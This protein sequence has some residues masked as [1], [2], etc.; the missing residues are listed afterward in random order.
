MTRSTSSSPDTR[1][2][3]IRHGQTEWNTQGI[4]RGL[5][6]VALSA[7]GL[8]EA[9]ALGQ[10]FSKIPLDAIY[11]SRL[12]RAQ[13]TA[14][15]IAD[16]QPPRSGEPRQTFGRP[17]HKVSLVHVEEGLTDI[18]RGLWEGL[19]HEQVQEKY[20]AL[21]KEWFENPAAVSFPGGESLKNI[22]RKA[23]GAFD[24]ISRQADG[25]TI[26]LVSHHVIIRVILCSLLN[27]DLNRFRQLEVETGSITE[28]RALYGQRVLFRLNETG[29]LREIAP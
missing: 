18:H 4:F 14:Q 6:D 23:C 16:A 29:H 22:Q 26:A 15:A 3:L 28:I 25:Q 11:T 5:S 8:D 24:R 12:K 13:D 10:Y 1:I 9:K 7:R 19:S 20:P 21:Y 17:P 2:F 27:M